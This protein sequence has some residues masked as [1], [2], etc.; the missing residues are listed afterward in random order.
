MI[1]YVTVWKDHEPTKLRWGVPVVRCKNCTFY[2]EE[3]M[4]YNHYCNGWCDE[5]EP[6]GFCAWGKN[7]EDEDGPGD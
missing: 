1:E 4:E 2:T 5:V 7:M 3:D 6:D